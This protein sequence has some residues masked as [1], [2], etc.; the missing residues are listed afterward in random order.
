MMTIC[1]AAARLLRARARLAVLIGL[2]PLFAGAVPGLAQPMLMQGD[3][4]V[5]SSGSFEYVVPIAVA[6]GVAGKIPAVSLVFNSASG[7]GQ[8]GVGWNLNASSMIHVCPKTMAQDGER[9]SQVYGAMTRLCLDGQKLMLVSGAYGQPGAEYRTEMES[10]RRVRY[11]GATA[12][13]SDYFI[14]EEPDGDRIEYGG[15]PDSSV[16]LSTAWLPISAQWLKR[17][18]SDPLGNTITYSYEKESGSA[19]LRARYL[20]Q[21]AYGG[22]AAKSLADSAWV[23]FEYEDRPDPQAG[24]SGGHETSLKRRLKSIKT[25]SGSS[26]LHTYGLTYETGAV[27]GKSRLKKIT[28]CAADGVCLPPTVMSFG[29]EDTSY[30]SFNSFMFPENSPHRN[31]IS[32]SSESRTFVGDVN[33]DGKSDQIVMSAGGTVHTWLSDTSEP[34]GFKVVRFDFTPVRNQSLMPDTAWPVMTGDFNGDGRMDVFRQLPNK[35]GINGPTYPAEW[36]FYLS[37]GD[38]TYKIVSYF[39]GTGLP[40]NTGISVLDLDGD[41][42]TDIISGDG[43]VSP[44]ARALHLSKGDGVFNKTSLGAGNDTGTSLDAAYLDANGDGLIDYLSLKDKTL[45]TFLGK[46]DGTFEA[47]LPTMVTIPKWPSSWQ[48]GDFNGDGV[49]DVILQTEAFPDRFGGPEMTVQ[50]Y[51]GR[52]DGTFVAGPVTT[53]TLPFVMAQQFGWLAADTN[54]DGRMD[55]ITVASNSYDEWGGV[56][57]LGGLQFWIARQ[58]GTFDLIGADPTLVDLIRN[59]VA[60]FPMDVLGRGSPDLVGI[61]INYRSLWRFSPLKQDLP[62]AI[63]TAPTSTVSWTSKTIAQARGDN[64]KQDRDN[65]K[66]GE[67]TG[68]QWPKVTAAPTTPIVTETVEVKG[69]AMLAT[70]YTYGTLLF[71]KSINGRGSAGFAWAQNDVQISRSGESFPTLTSRQVFSQEFPYTGKTVKQGSGR[72]GRWD[73]LLQGDI[74]FGCL[75]PVDPAG[76]TLS[77]CAGSPQPGQRFHIYAKTTRA[78]NFDLTGALL[79][80]KLTEVLSQDAHGNVLSFRE[81][82][83]AAGAT[84]AKYVT[85]TESVYSNDLSKWQLRKLVRST[86]TKSNDGADGGGGQSPGGGGGEQP[87]GV[88]PALMQAIYLLLLED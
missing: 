57:D 76:I 15:S 71:D 17:K 24:Y 77:E 62:A 55:L 51:Y 37:N 64:Y 18:E 87:A 8:L 68:Y 54:G 48:L 84:A 44:P 31:A 88:S 45:T 49:A 42:R 74:A 1:C 40:Q 65:A 2:G 58:D 4:K 47:S 46:G 23:T 6:P 26:V 43:N 63:S 61:D 16:I 5:T 22:N 78:K 30:G 28:Q 12:E 85:R 66:P 39:P 29:A 10:F 41:G 69:T 36:L 56:M 32:A 27:T 75:T 60:L 21:I 9:G 38:G 67:S 33:G 59:G 11:V 50:P 73:E 82:L 14:V 72:N 34:S 79:G 81:S 19:G 53:K 83:F 7:N 20:T 25:S 13:A 80:D 52:G 3:H 86:V 70:R 35:I